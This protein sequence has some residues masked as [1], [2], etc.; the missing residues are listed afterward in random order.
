MLPFDGFAIN[1]KDTKNIKK[2]SNQKFKIIGSIAAGVKPFKKK[3]N[4][5]NAVEIMTGAII[6]NGFDTIIPIE[7]IV[8]FPNKENA[9]YI[10]VNKKITKY[11][12][13]RFKGSDYKKGEL[14]VKK[15][16][17][18][19][20]NHIL[21]LKSLGIKDIKVKKKI[22]ILFFSTGNEISNSDKIPDWKVRNSN[23]HYIK[24]LD[25]NFLFNFEKWWNIER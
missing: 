7:Q 10:L 13:V 1:S 23:N 20:P 22:N 3:I 5:F 18:I 24:N 4:K 21:A 11:N 14:V 6:P 25:Q 2:K 16:T 8:F 9:K 15:N 12:H 19:Q 17:I